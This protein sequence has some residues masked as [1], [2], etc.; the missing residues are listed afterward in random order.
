MSSVAW[1]V[2]GWLAC[3]LLATMLVDMVWGMLDRR[4]RLHAIEENVRALDRF[5]DAYAAERQRRAGR[6]EEEGNERCQRDSQG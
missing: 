2:F 6:T 4:R 5:V 3:A 1:Q